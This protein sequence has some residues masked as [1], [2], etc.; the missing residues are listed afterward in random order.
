MK[1]FLALVLA[2]TLALSCVA[3]ASADKANDTL[4]LVGYAT[5][6]SFDPN[7]S[8]GYDKIAAHALYAYLW[9]YDEDGNASSS[10]VD[11]WTTSEDGT[12]LICNL[13]Q[14]VTFTDGTPF[15]AD[16][17]LACYEDACESALMGYTTLSVIAKIEK[18]DDYTINM[19]KG[20]AYSSI[21]VFCCEYMPMYSAAAYD[22]QDNFT[23]TVVSAGPYVLD[24]KDNVSGYVYMT[25]NPDYFRGEPA[26]KNVELHTPL[27]SAVALVALENGEIQIAP[28]SMSK[29][30]AAIAESEGFSNEIAT[31][32]STK[33]VLCWGEPFVSDQ[34]LRLAIAYGIN[35]VNAMIYNGEPTTDPCTD[36]YAAK[37]LGSYA[38]KTEMITYD[39]EKAAEYLAASNYDGSTLNITITPDQ[40]QVAVSVQN[41]LQMLGINTEI[42]VMDDNS[43]WNT[44]ETATCQITITDFGVAYTAPEEMLSYFQ[45]AGYYGSLGLC[46]SDEAYDSNLAIAAQTW[47]RDERE[48]YTLAAIQASQDLAYY[49]PL[50]EC[51]F[52]IVYSSDVVGVEGIWS[53]TYNFHLWKL[54]WAE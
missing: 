6:E 13:R 51:G 20:A 48:P 40:E 38:G 4:V 22:E 28:I 26:I 50:F 7:G 10:L 54:S 5:C 9:D 18:V 49:I 15:N 35:R 12:Y 53:A 37:L 1:K 23:D 46:T 29:A 25:A 2:M 27:D 24:H 33:T 34:N 52:S 44:V 42:L 31:G 17:V 47:D 45:S 14:D 43:W 16:A 11:T 32:W 19:Y 8:A 39:P 21:E 30:D 41:D 36:Y 3:V